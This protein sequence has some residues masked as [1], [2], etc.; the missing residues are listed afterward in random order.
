M[1]RGLLADAALT[2]PG[3][4]DEVLDFRKGLELSFH[5]REGVRDGQAFTKEQSISLFEGGLGIFRDSVTLQ[6]DFVDGPGFSRIAVHKHEW[7]DVLNDF[8]AARDHGQFSDPAKLVHGAHPANDGMV[9]VI[10]FVPKGTDIPQPD[11][12]SQLPTLGAT[13]GG[14]VIATT[15]TSIAGATSSTPTG[16]TTVGSGGTSTSIA[17][18]GTGAVSTTTVPAT[19][20]TGG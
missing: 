12:A 13:D 20:T 8:G 14:A 3:E 6:T 4:G 1:R 5:A 9:F 7:R 19:T 10:A 11:W 2:G 17:T 16:G 15:T 18:G